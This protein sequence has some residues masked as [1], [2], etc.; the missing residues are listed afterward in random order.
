MNGES[1]YIGKRGVKRIDSLTSMRFW[2]MVIIFLSHLEF[3]KLYE[4]GDIYMKYFHNPAV[5]VDFFFMLSGFGLAYS[6]KKVE[7]IDLKSS[8]MFGMERVKKIY[9]CYVAML[10]FC[11]PYC[12]LWDM[13]NGKNIVHAVVAVVVKLCMGLTML[14][15]ATGLSSVSHL[16]NGVGWFLSTLFVLYILCPAILKLNEKIEKRIKRIITVFIFNTIAM[17]VFYKLFYLIEGKTIFDDLVYGSPYIR[18][19]YLIGGV[20]I[21]DIVKCLKEY[22]MSNTVRNIM[23]VIVILSNIG[24]FFFRNICSFDVL[25]KYVIDYCLCG[26]LIYVCTNEKGI[27]NRILSAKWNIKL[28][29][30][31]MYIYLIHYP[32]R[33][34]IDW[35][36]NK[37][38][39]P[40]TMSNGFIEVLLIIVITSIIVTVISFYKSSKRKDN[41]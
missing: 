36:Y 29:Q 20:L 35:I 1:D 31:T 30:I 24:W 11:I 22:R 13:E 14:Q 33:M 5:A 19:F 27:I 3:L 12:L 8:L 21:S 17:L 7:K 16:L 9:G 28:G 37:L 32:I 26:L 10:I 34:Y 23:G 6:N 4:Y 15:S 18:V 38:N 25:V 41:M 40:R 39:I 2:M